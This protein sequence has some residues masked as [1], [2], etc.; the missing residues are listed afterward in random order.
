[1]QIELTQYTDADDLITAIGEI[2]RSNQVGDPSSAILLARNLL[3]EHTNPDAVGVSGPTGRE[4]G[5]F[6]KMYKQ[7]QL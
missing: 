4:K 5:V 6:E 3:P 7:N 1:M 2:P